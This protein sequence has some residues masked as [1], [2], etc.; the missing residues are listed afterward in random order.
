MPAKLN[1]KKSDRQLQGEIKDHGDIF[2][3]EEQRENFVTA[4]EKIRNASGHHGDSLRA[5]SPVWASEVARSLKQESL[6]AGYQG[7]N[8]RHSKK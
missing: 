3:L 4:V 6:L 8:E 1:E 7:E 2:L 5:S